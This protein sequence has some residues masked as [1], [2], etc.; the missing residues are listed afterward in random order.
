MLG[1]TSCRL[2]SI[3]TGLYLRAD[4]EQCS[5]AMEFSSASTWRVSSR[6]Q[7]PHTLRAELI[8]VVC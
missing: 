1:E 8:V 6:A 5:L 2:M 3:T 4:D 7:V